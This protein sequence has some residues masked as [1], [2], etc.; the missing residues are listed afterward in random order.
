[1]FKPH[2]GDCINPECGRTG[3]IIPVRRGICQY[4][5]HE[6]KQRAK[7]QRSGNESSDRKN[8][9][10]Q[11][12]NRGFDVVSSSSSNSLSRSSKKNGG[13][14]AKGRNDNLLKG[15]GLGHSGI[16]LYNEKGEEI[17]PSHIPSP[18]VRKP[19]KKKPIQYR[20]KRTGEAEVFEE[21]WNALEEKIC[22]VCGRQIGEPSASNFAH[23]LPKA[24]N[25][26]PLFKLNP[27]N[28]KL[29]CHDSYSSCHH[30]FDKEPRSTLKEPM[31]KKVFE[32][33]EKLK[34]EY[35]TLKSTL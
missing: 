16:C 28:I 12:K 21:I 31:W 32:L 8:Q 19:I 14:N 23:I 7:F 27:D 9:G 2:I 6:E 33:E 11:Q 10:G 24:L 1:M 13:W 35:K 5:N 26:Y 25:K 17:N 4:C 29:F 15:V 20:R 22:F 18:M 30:R 34:E 3:V